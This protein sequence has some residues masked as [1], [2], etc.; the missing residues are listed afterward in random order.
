[1]A[2]IVFEGLDGSGKSTL[3]NRL[4]HILKERKIEHDLTREPGG[5]EL[6]DKL[7]D[8]IIAK[9]PHAPRPRAELL[10]Y[11]ASRAQLVETWIKP[12]LEQGRWVISDRFAASSIAFQAAGRSIDEADVNWLNQ[13]AT[14]GLQPD[15]YILLDISVEESKRRR[16]K[17]QDT[18][19]VEEDRI[20]AEKDDFHARVRDGFLKQAKAN[21]QQWFILSAQLPTEQ[22]LEHVLQKLKD[23][24]W[25]K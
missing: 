17:R 5:T 11:E 2:F 13:F 9:G 25:L 4:S 18:F 20:E 24:Q 10:M 21:P 6:G 23:R 22:M 8:L 14:F 15:L 16:Q 19:G 7:R 3:I 12:K 1:M